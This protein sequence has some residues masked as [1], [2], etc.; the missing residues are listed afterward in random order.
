MQEQHILDPEA[1]TLGF[2]RR[3]AAYK[4]PTL[5]LHD[6]DRLI[7]ILTDPER[8]VQLILAGKA[9][10]ADSEGQDMIRQWIRF[11]RRP[12]VCGRAV[13]LSD[14]D[15]LLTEQ[16]VGGVDVWI[17]TPRRPW[18][19]CGTSGMKVLVN[20]GLNLSELDG[21][22]A[23]AYTPQVGW[24]LGDGREH[25]SD[26]VWDAAEAGALYALLENEVVP[27]F[28]RR[29]ANGIPAEWLSKMR[30]S[31]SHLTVSFSANR[32]IREYTDQYYVPAATRYD[33]RRA[34]NGALGVAITNRQRRLQ[35]GWRSMSFV[36]VRVETHDGYH[37]FR[38][39]V[40]FGDLDPAD[41][42]VELY[43]EAPA[44]ASLP[45][46]VHAWGQS[47]GQQEHLHLL[48][49]SRGR[50]TRERFHA[51]DH[52]RVPRPR[53]TARNEPGSMG[54]LIAPCDL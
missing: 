17:N 13:F 48:R 43:A 26:P 20:G 40:D 2:A 30:E 23:E 21:W 27:Q 3:F 7:R 16:L 12:E 34:N 54:A 51:P 14:Y 41:V 45:A 53:G 47:P 5:L 52:S 10:P 35:K 39:T 24:A 1:L 36:E 32:A 29:D 6:P 15:M 19:A 9:H 50:Q 22:W 28:Y 46:P 38:A 31:M 11:I 42:L 33:S 18:E 44:A 49:A 4:R 25:D 8:P 37:H